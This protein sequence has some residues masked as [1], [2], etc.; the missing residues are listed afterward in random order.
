MEG[1]E[2]ALAPPGVS[3]VTDEQFQPSVFYLFFLGFFYVQKLD[4]NYNLVTGWWHRRLLHLRFFHAT[5]PMGAISKGDDEPVASF[6]LPSN[7]HICW[8]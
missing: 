5:A 6:H 4:E 2:P 1:P 3:S 7:L 8:K